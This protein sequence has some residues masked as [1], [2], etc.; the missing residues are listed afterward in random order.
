MEKVIF[1]NPSN[2]SK[3]KDL[4]LNEIINMIDTADGF[5]SIAIAYFTQT[6]IANALIRRT[7]NGRRSQLILN[8]SDLLRPI[9]S[10]QTEIVISKNLI[11]LL[12]LGDPLNIKSL[13]FRSKT[14]YSNMH[15]KFIVSDRKLIFGSLNWTQTA[16]QNNYEVVILSE[17]AYLIKEFNKEFDI[18]WESS[19]RLYFQDS[20]I[21]SIICPICKYADGIDFESYGPFCTFCGHQFKIE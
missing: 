11:E 3:A 18:L 21:R 1:L 9:N 12:K 7:K 2:N 15:H 20:R 19:Q 4:V 14:T 16:L 5:L 10:D 17:N 13:G 6:E 8:T